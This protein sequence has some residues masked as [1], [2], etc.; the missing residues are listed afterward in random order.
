MT[1][2]MRNFFKQSMLIPKPT[3]TEDTLPD[4]NGRVFIVTGGYTG[5]GLYLCKILY[6]KHG[7][8]YIAGRDKEKYGKAVDFIKDAFKE[9]KGR[10]EF[11]HLDLASLKSVKAAATEFMGKERRLDVLT[12]NAGV[13]FPPKGSKTEDGYELTMGTN[14]VGPYLF[15]QLLRPLL[16]KT[17]A[18]SP[19]G[20]VRVTWAA[21]LAIDTL[22]PNYG[23]DFDE[24][25]VPKIHG[26]QTDYGQSKAANVF[27]GTEYAR[28]YSKDGVL[29]VSWNP[30]NLKTELYRHLGDIQGSIAPLFLFP[31]DIGA[32]VELYAGW[33]PDIT[34]ENNGALVIPWGRLH[35]PR[36]QLL[37]AIKSKK[38]GG[39]GVAEQFWDWCDQQVKAHL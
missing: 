8:V 9:S 23:V 4:Q 31:A 27:L 36:S 16:N 30:G 7:T 25:G 33:S 5:V 21:S 20:T 12:N 15:T 1:E 13:M 3:F 17:A 26:I 24:K 19:P 22:A 11:L 6:Q 34:A 2:K 39:M 35:T 18:S 32:Y 37:E 14:C 29:S 10:L 28:R 38:D